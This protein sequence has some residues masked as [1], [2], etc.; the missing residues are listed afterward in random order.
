[1]IPRAETEL[2]GA[3]ATVLLGALEPAGQGLQL[4]DLCCGAGNLVCGIASRLPGL[5]AAACDL[6]T[7]AV[8]LARA[9]LARHGLTGRVE[10]RQGDLFAA[11]D[12]L[13][14]EGR[15]DLIV[16][17]P[18][19]ISSKRLA[20]DR[21]ALLLHEPREA[22]DGG[23]YGLTI[24]QR[25][26][27]EAPRFLRPGGALAFEVGAGQERQV[28]TLFARA[29]GWQEPV[30]HRDAAGVARVLRAARC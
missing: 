29:G 7:P 1:L 2:L 25:V 16:C 15:V 26:V 12:G 18:P 14:L 20:G 3:T 28:A 19:Y 17:N 21:A 8:E 24:H 10:A 9:N 22:F 11:L 23:A 4:L 13:A 6:T 5:R 30:I 27:R